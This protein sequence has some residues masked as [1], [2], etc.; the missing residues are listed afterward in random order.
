VPLK[1][2]RNAKMMQQSTATI[3]HGVDE[4]RN[5][6]QIRVQHKYC[7]THYVACRQANDASCHSFLLDLG[8]C[9]MVLCLA[10]CYDMCSNPFSADA[11][12]CKM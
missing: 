12:S 10:T 9:P 5:T 2:H 3:N 8:S 7:G 4:G 1:L 6:S 11:Y